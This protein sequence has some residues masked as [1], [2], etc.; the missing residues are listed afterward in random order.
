MPDHEPTAGLCES[1]RHRR[2]VR[3]RRGSVFIYCM[4]SEQDRRFPKYPMLP[5]LRCDGYRRDENPNEKAEK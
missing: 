3:S 2:E 1:C 5:V 4:Q